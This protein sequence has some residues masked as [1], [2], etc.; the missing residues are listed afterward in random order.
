MG[1]AVDLPLR[2][3]AIGRNTHVE[4]IGPLAVHI[5]DVAVDPGA[6]AVEIEVGVPCLERIE[7]PDNQAKAFCVSHRALHDLD[8]VTQAADW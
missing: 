5:V 2:D 1:K 3:Q 7:G 8:R 4:R 6:Q